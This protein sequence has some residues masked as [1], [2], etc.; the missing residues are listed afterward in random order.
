MGN[1]YCKTLQQANYKS[2]QHNAERVSYQP[3]AKNFE[4]TNFW[5][6][7]G[8]CANIYDSYMTQL[9]DE[10][11]KVALTTQMSI[12][13]FLR[14]CSQNRPVGVSDDNW[15]Q[16]L[17][18]TCSDYFKVGFNGDLSG[19]RQTKSLNTIVSVPNSP[20]RSS[21]DAVMGL[22]MPEDTPRLSHSSS[23]SIFEFA[24]RFA[25]PDNAEYNQSDAES[26]SVWLQ[27]TE[28]SSFY[29]P[30]STS[31]KC[32]DEFVSTG[33][34]GAGADSDKVWKSNRTALCL[35]DVPSGS[36]EESLFYDENKISTTFASSKPGSSVN[37]AFRGDLNCEALFDEIK[38]NRG[39]SRAL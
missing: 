24:G 18:S 35:G 14:I 31:L 38:V 22:S 34:V 25:L 5:K 12:S 26:T 20:S 4:K 23:V 1:Y 3:M 13:E 2:S 30:N 21:I 8:R 28:D 19:R 6:S 9:G 17:N 16:F 10:M 32:Q 36:Y 37:I 7:K 29:D 27:D 39:I 15:Q 33:D 11:E